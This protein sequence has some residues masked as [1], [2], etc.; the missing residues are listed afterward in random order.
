[1]YENATKLFQML[2][3][4]NNLNKSG[5]PYA[6]NLRYLDV[7]VSLEAIWRKYNSSTKCLTRF[8]ME[9]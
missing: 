5:L 2:P 9:F 7:S 1:M 6:C 3:A 8:V 4:E